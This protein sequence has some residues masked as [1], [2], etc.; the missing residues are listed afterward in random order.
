MRCERNG[1]I[2]YHP[3][4]QPTP[5]PVQ[6]KKG[7][8]TII[9]TDRLIAPVDTTRIDFI[10]MGDKY[11]CPKCGYEIVTGFGQ[12]MVDYTYPQEMLKKLVTNAPEAI[13]ILRK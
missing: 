11:K 13:E 12:M 2:V 6:E 4:E 1:V 3:Y 10:A 8:L 5:G 9:N 7:N